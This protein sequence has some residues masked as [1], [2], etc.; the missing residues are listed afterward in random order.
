MA[1]I[2]S[3][4]SSSASSTAA[5]MIAQPF[6]FP[7]EEDTE[8]VWQKF[9]KESTE[10]IQGADPKEAQVIFLGNIH[11]EKWW[12]KDWRGEIIKHYGPDAIVLC[13]G[14][15][16]SKALP[17]ENVTSFIPK[18]QVQVFGWDDMLCFKDVS[19]MRTMNTLYEKYKESSPSANWSS[20]DIDSWRE[21]LFR[22]Y[23]KCQLRSN[24]MIKTSR[25]F[26]RNHLKQGQKLIVIAG[27]DH[28]FQK[29]RGYN[30]LDYFKGVKAAMIL[31]KVL[32]SDP[33]G[34]GMRHIKDKLAERPSKG[35]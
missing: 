13:E 31:P 27:S 18:S 11:T 2:S 17:L 5:S 19:D 10:E 20:D 34:D 14:F 9:L 4:S 28:H 8:A 15:P 26:L 1:S 35:S 7:K 6:V 30:V 3:S 23:G 16:A 32:S 33:E 12:Q 24:S 25:V 29:E 21:A 22:S